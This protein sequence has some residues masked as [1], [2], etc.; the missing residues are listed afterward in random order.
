MFNITDQQIKCS[1]FEKARSYEVGHH[2]GLIEEHTYFDKLSGPMLMVAGSLCPS[3][4]LKS[5]QTGLEGLSFQEG[6]QHSGSCSSS[7]P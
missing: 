5:I 1:C 6:Q 3:L 7:L 2:V 4:L